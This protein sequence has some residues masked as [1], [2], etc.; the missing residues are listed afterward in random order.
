MLKKLC[1]FLEFRGEIKTNKTLTF[2]LKEINGAQGIVEGEGEGEGQGEERRRWVREVCEGVDDVGGEV[3]EGG[4]PLRI[5]PPHH[6][7]RYELRADAY[8]L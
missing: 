3:G 4:D 5:H 7:H 1:L 6:R 8:P 2:D